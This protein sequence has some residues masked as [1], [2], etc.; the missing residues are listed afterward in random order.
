MVK[1]LNVVKLF[2][3]DLKVGQVNVAKPQEHVG[4]VNN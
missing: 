1:Q 2:V 4:I 3:L